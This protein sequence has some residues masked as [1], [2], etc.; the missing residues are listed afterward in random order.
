MVVFLLIVFVYTIEMPVITLHPLKSYLAMI[1]SSA[2]GENHMFR[3]VIA[4]V[5]G[6]QTNIL[7]DGALSCGFFVSAVLFLNKLIGDMHTGVAGLERDL[8]ASGWVQVPEFHEGAV[9][10]WE[11]RPGAGGAMHLHA[12]FFVGDQRAISNGSNT[13]HMPEEH[14]YTYDDTRK[15]I[16]IWW[17]PKLDA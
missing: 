13:T 6:I 7:R 4:S 14:H 12:G 17:Y 8:A 1:R 2:K 10:I 16:R 11:P 15:I 3:T 5:D 9:L